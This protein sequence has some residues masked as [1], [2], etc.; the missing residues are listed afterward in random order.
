MFK[1]FNKVAYL[2]LDCGQTE[3]HIPGFISLQILTT[4][5]N[6]AIIGKLYMTNI[7]TRAQN[8]LGPPYSHDKNI[9][10]T[11]YIGSVSVDKCASLF[12]KSF[13]DLL[14]KYKTMH[15]HE[16]IPLYVNTMGW[17]TGLGLSILT[18]IVRSVV[19]THMFAVKSTEELSILEHGSIN[20]PN[21]KVP[22]Y[23]FDTLYENSETISD[24][25]KQPPISSKWPISIA[26]LDT[27]ISES[28]KIL[29]IHPK[30]LRNVM[31]H[32]YFHSDGGCL[33][34]FD[35]P[36][37][38]IKPYTISWSSVSI[39]I[40]PVKGL[41]FDL[42]AIVS[43]LVLSIVGLSVFSDHS[44]YTNCNGLRIRLASF[45]DSNL[46]EC[47]GAAIIR[48]IDPVSKTIQILTPIS[49]E[50]LESK[51]IR[52]IVFKPGYIAPKGLI[53]EQYIFP[54]DIYPEEPYKSIAS[55]YNNTSM[56]APN[57]RK[58]RQNILR[59]SHGT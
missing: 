28:D 20:C 57:T 9:S 34:K 25:K 27:V 6:S 33:Y 12:I 55:S 16:G 11:R 56:K 31:L 35:N 8:Y 37:S 1:N 46:P 24:W 50:I 21:S 19:P 38:S 26:S 7:K 52:T 17:V 53:D 59:K 4:E 45:Q 14:M 23:V 47:E 5:P 30:C 48:A 49:L 18:Y 58:V 29:K 3:F 54:L 13:D 22:D 32:S 36:I 39:I 51:N 41:H 43:S 44:K 42:K 15:S 2:D 40:P 10:Y